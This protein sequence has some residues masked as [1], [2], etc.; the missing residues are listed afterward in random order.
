[1]KKLLTVLF[2]FAGIVAGQERTPPQTEQDLERLIKYYEDQP[3]VVDSLTNLLLKRFPAGDR[4]FFNQFNLNDLYLPIPEVELK[5]RDFEKTFKPDKLEL[6]YYALVVRSSKVADYRRALR[7][8]K[9]IVSD[10]RY[11]DAVRA[12]G[13]NAD[14]KNVAK[15]QKIVKKRIAKSSAGSEASTDDFAA[16]AGA[17]G[18]VL[19]LNKKYKEGL[20]YS[21]I[22]YEAYPN[23]V[24]LKLNHYLLL[25]YNGF[26]TEALPYFEE[27]VKAGFASDEVKAQLRVAHQK[28]FPDQ[29]FE[30]YLAGLSSTLQSKLD[31]SLSQQEIAIDASPFALLDSRG[32]IRTFEDF[33]GKILVIDFWATWCGPCVGALPAMQKLVDKYQ[34]DTTVQFL[35]INTLEPGDAHSKATN[36]FAKHNYEMDLFIDPMDPVT[37]QSPAYAALSGHGIPYKLIIDTTGVIR[38]KSVGFAG[39]NDE[40]IERLSIMIERTR[41]RG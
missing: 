12:I 38:Y 10:R 2:I 13:E 5:L 15:L 24:H 29:N 4:A 39:G 37:K 28:V 35:F 23:D 14:Q 9:A 16:L 3:L 19:L 32:N 17:Y 8:I 27:L 7:Y 36:Y 25:S 22:A 11:A 33:K 40:L 34:S 26:Y 21:K 20:K 30:K 31:A 1:M 6:I 18:S 41:K